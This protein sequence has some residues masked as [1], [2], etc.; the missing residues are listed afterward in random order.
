ML[1]ALEAARSKPDLP[2]LVGLTLRLAANGDASTCVRAAA[3]ACD[4]ASE[5]LL[6]ETLRNAVHQHSRIAEA[7]AAHCQKRLRARETDTPP[8]DEFGGCAAVDADMCLQLLQVPTARGVASQA[9]VRALSHGVLTKEE[10]RL[11]ACPFCAKFIT[12]SYRITVLAL[13]IQY[14]MALTFGCHLQGR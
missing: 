8:D 12:F 7:V 3:F 14:S 4:L 6:S 9:L 11:L 10:A 1:Q 2:P 13:C 5:P